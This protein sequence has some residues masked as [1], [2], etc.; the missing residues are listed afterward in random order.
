[1]L[2]SYQPH[3]RSCLSVCLSV[4]PSFC[5]IWLPAGKHKHVAKL[6]LL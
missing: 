4:Y 3:Y 2:P 5:L 1:M 6:K